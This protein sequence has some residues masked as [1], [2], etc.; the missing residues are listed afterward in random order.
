MVTGT[1]TAMGIRTGHPW[2]GSRATL[3]GVGWLG[4]TEQGST[5]WQRRRAA[6][7]DWRRSAAG[8]LG[9]GTQRRAVAPWWVSPQR[10]AR[11]HGGLAATGGT[12]AFPRTRRTTPRTMGTPARLLRGTMAR[13]RARLARQDTGQPDGACRQ[14]RAVSPCPSSRATRWG[15]RLESRGD[16]ATTTATYS[17]PRSA[18]PVTGN[19]RRGSTGGQCRCS[20]AAD[21]GARQL[22]PQW[23]ADTGQPPATRTS[24]R[25]S[26][27][28]RTLRRRSVQLARGRECI[29]LP[30]PAAPF[31]QALFD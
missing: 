30:I 8:S 20:N 28:P 27:F 25:R 29:S 23:G 15:R 13:D 24:S 21:M 31:P 6:S 10:M 7:S 5:A 14:S 16:S 4:T 19:Q 2:N 9:L 26:T 12:V 18:A 22:P 3:E 17:P 11:L 1:D